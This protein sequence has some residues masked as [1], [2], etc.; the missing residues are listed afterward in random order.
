MSVKPSI[1]RISKGSNVP[2]QKG[3]A[4]IP[5]KYQ[6]V[7]FLKENLQGFNSSSDKHSFKNLL[8]R[9]FNRAPGPASYKI[10]APSAR[11]SKRGYT[12]GFTSHSERYPSESIS[13]S[14]Q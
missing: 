8:K 12:N 7:I 3:S 1:S 13:Q 10:K 11:Y 6:H 2:K 4:S 9:R 14:Y 5:S